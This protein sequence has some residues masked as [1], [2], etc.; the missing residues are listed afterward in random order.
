MFHLL[1]GHKLPKGLRKNHHPSLSLT[2][3][4][5]KTTIQMLLTITRSVILTGQYFLTWSLA[6]RK[7]P[8]M[9]KSTQ[10][11]KLDIETMRSRPKI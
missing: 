5:T 10:N 3:T 11:T 7:C 2:T 1:Q 4:R 9:T 6:L 8:E